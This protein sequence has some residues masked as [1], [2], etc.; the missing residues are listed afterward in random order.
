M[1]LEMLLNRYSSDATNF[2]KEINKSD[3][4][5]FHEF[6]N[7]GGFLKSGRR[8]DSEYDFLPDEKEMDDYITS[9]LRRL[10]ANGK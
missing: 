2:L 10:L 6:E 3:V 5:E 9:S 4:Q 8:M 7:R 1:N